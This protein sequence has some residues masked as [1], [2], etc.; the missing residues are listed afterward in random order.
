MNENIMVLI[1]KVYSIV[2]GMLFILKGLVIIIIILIKMFSC[3]RLIY[4]INSIIKV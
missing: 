1:L 2:F 3:L 4:I